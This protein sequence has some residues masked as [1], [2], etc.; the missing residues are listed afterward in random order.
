MLKSLVVMGLFVWG[1]AFAQDMS[2][3][4]DMGTA[5]REMPDGS[6]RYVG[7]CLTHED[8]EKINFKISKTILDTI[9]PSELPKKEL[10]TILSKFDNVLLS[11]VLNNLDIYDMADRGASRVSIFQD[12]ID[13]MT[14]ESVT[15]AQRSD[16]KL[17]RF[18]VGIGGGNGAY[19]VFNE[20]VISGRKT[21]SSCLLPLMV[22]LT[23]VT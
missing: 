9:S 4:E 13:D 11:E 10:S 3:M 20:S 14:V 18:N 8:Y 21:S 12:F 15:L 19:L 6:S 5:Y 23:T 7:K 16:L 2:T 1:S 22:S 17:I